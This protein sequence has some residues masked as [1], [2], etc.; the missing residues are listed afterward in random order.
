MSD[1]GALS[2]YLDI[3]VKQGT[4]GITLSQSAYATRI[5]NNAGMTSCNPVHVPMEPRFKLSKESSAHAVDATEY[6]SIV[7]SL[8]YLVNTRP[9]L[10][11][12]VGYVSRFMEKP[13]TEHLAAVK[14]ILRYIAGTL[15]YG[16]RYVNGTGMARLIGFSDSD[17]AEDLDTCKSTTGIIFLLGS[18][19]ISWQSQ[20]QRIVALSSCEGEYIAATTASCQGVWLAQLLAE[21]KKED[22][23]PFTL[24]IDNQSAIALI[25]NPLFHETSK[26]MDT[27][28][29]YIREC[30]ADGKLQV[31]AI[32]TG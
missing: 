3:K 21:L 15:N 5:L 10:A 23:K 19:A 16:C 7:G 26:N 32:G 20:K 31:E 25:K 24:R 27:R 2:F 22:V 9:D 12:L 18:S 8:R 6:R 4:D 29:H 14:R 13:T 17:M 30:V 11:Y 28:Y 1:L